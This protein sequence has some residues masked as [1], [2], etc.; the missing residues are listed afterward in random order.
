MYVFGVFHLS[1]FF[2]NKQIST[3]CSSAWDN[4]SLFIQNGLI[5]EQGASEILW[6]CRHRTVLK[7][8]T[9]LSVLL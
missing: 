4:N 7:F 5:P 3:V 6:K 2:E 9:L 8:I 1:F